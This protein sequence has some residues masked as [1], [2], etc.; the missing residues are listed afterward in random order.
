[1]ILGE[2]GEDGKPYAGPVQAVF[3]DSNRRGF[4]RA[5]LQTLIY[6]TAQA[7]LQQ[8]SIWG[9]QATAGQAIKVAGVSLRYADS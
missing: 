7:V 9:S 8:N 5:K 6:E 2:I 4:Q 1:M 3:L